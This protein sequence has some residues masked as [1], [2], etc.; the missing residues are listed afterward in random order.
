MQ[1]V[2]YT[3]QWT[4][5][6]RAVETE[7]GDQAIFADPFARELAAPRGFELLDR[8]GGSGLRPFIAIRT[9]YLDQTIDTV[10][11]ETAIRQIRDRP[12][13]CDRPGHRVS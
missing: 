1:A 2:S 11:H 3:A 4:A 8:N 13:N 5:A 10:L 6:A 7:R 12:I 9:R